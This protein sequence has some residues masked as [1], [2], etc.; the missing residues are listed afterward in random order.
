MAKNGK[1]ARRAYITSIVLMV[2]ITLIVMF[3]GIA[4]CIGYSHI[5]DP[6]MIWPTIMSDSHA[7]FKG[8]FLVT[9]FAMAMSTADSHLNV[10]SS[11]IAHDII[12]PLRKDKLTDRQQ[13]YVAKVA[14]FI[15]GILATF[16]A[17]STSKYS[18]ALL[19]LLFLIANISNPIFVAPFLLAVFG[20][21]CKENVAVL[22]M[23]A[24]II[25]ITFWRKCIPDI[26]GSFVAMIVNGLTML[27]AHYSLPRK[28]LKA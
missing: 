10:S 24:G 20:F 6:R 23:V 7:I 28:E 25:T 16:P 15:I 18:D 9:L 4:A 17:L 2:I 27:L 5:T 12:N 3:I 1:Q 13:L 8:L 22:G 26:D 21:R 19:R 14:C 11:M